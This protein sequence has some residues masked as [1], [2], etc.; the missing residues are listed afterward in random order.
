MKPYFIK[1]S[2][3]KECPRCGGKMI[4]KEV[5]ISNIPV[6]GW[7]CRECEKVIIELED[8]ENAIQGKRG[9]IVARDEIQ[10]WIR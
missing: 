9:D 3:Q 4:K 10:H 8:A 2:P 6:P 7:E 1:M 5:K